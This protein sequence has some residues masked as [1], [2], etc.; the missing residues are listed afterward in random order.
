MS[1]YWAGYGRTGFLGIFEGEGHFNRGAGVEIQSPRGREVATI[2]ERVDER[3]TK[4]LP[5]DGTIFGTTDAVIDPA[6]ELCKLAEASAASLPVLVADAERLLDGT[7]ILHVMPWDDV[8]LTEWVEEL[9]ARFQC[10]VMLL[11]LA[12]LPKEK[13]ANGCGKPGC[14]DGGGGNCGSGCGT[15]SKGSV[16]NADELTEYFL[17]LRKQMEVGRTSLV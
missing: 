17:N 3:F 7:L 16:K 5:A 1:R 12:T 6:T 15:C 2:L 8:D 9:S 13:V 14:G 11:N 10:K 4:H